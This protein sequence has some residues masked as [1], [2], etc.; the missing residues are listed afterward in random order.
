MP[1]S[2]Y[3]D[4]NGNEQVLSSSPSALSGLLDVS[5]SGATQGQVLTKG[6][7]SWEASTLMNI[8]DRYATT[9]HIVGYWIDDR[10]IYEKTI[11]LSYLP[12]N[13]TSTIPHGITNLARVLKY[14]GG[15]YDSNSGVNMPL[16]FV[17]GNFIS[18]AVVGADIQ[19]TANS[20]RSNLVG[21]MTLR[22]FK[23]T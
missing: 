23:T 13:A 8:P 4:E 1:K 20:D 6:A 15:A 11:S 21:Y 5:V 19:I 16:P 22:Y 14:E 2:I 9:E 17:G 10:P 3:Y 12:N 18:V 7:S